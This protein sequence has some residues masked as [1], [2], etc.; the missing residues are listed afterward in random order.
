MLR[1]DLEQAG[2]IVLGLCN[3][4][5]ILV[6]YASHTYSTQREEF[7]HPMEDLTTYLEAICV[8]LLC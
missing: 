5:R 7:T 6:C 3:V 1:N 4:L 8:L 2:T